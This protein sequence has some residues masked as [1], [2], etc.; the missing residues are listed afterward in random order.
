MICQQYPSGSVI[1]TMNSPERRPLVVDIFRKHLRDHGG[2]A[3]AV[4]WGSEASQQKRFEVLSQ[5]A[6]LDKK[7]ILDVG[8]GL[9]HFL[10]WLKARDISVRYTGVDITPEMIAVAA[11]AHEDATFLTGTVEQ[12]CDHSDAPFDYIF[13]SGIF[14]LDT[15]SG[16]EN[17]EK[18]LRQMFSLAGQGV[19]FNSLSR[20]ADTM[21][22]GEFY[23][24]PARVLDMCRS[25]TP[26]VQLRHDYHPA[27]F[28]CY[29]YRA[30]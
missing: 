6:D 19:A 29:L 15:D 5:V 21:D 27:D 7:S 12:F 30:D 24:D 14:Y 4:G 23:A 16:Y 1:S 25:I 28:T 20:W 26:K 2:G 17:M 22:E 13:A 9:G 10:D 18:T 3:A 11:K 8:C